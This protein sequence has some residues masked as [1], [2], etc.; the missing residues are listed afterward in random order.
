MIHGSVLPYWINT[1][2]LMDFCLYL[3][4]YKGIRIMD[5]SSPAYRADYFGIIKGQVECWNCR[6]ETPVATIILCEHQLRWDAEDAFENEI[7]PTVLKNII[8][9]SDEAKSRITEQAPWMSFLASNTA[10]ETYLGNSCIDCKK[11]QGDWFLHKPDGPFFPQDDEQL[12]NLSLSWHSIPVSLSAS[13]SQSLWM[14]KIIK[15]FPRS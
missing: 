3:N 6:K 7:D 8:K 1:A 12:N 4:K 5:D 14:D 10:Q 9:I 11:L 13:G 15:L 2:Y